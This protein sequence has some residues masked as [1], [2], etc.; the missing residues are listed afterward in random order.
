MSSPAFRRVA[1]LSL[2][3][4]LFV[5]I[6]GAYVRASGSGAGCG[7]HWPN[8]NGELIPRS[9]TAQTVIEF[10]HR[11]TSG[12]ALLLS[13]AVCVMAVRAFTK[14]HPTRRFAIAQLVLMLTEAALGALLVKAELV[15][16]NATAS[17]AAAMSIHLINTFLLVA[18][19]VLTVFHA[20]EGDVRA[21]WRGLAGG[22][23]WL[24]MSLVMLVGVSGAIAALGDTLVQQSVNNPFVDLLIRLRI[25]HPLIA[26]VAAAVM[27]F[28]GRF[29][30]GA[31]RGWTIALWSLVVLQLFA[32]LTNV[33]LQAPTW[34]QLV[35]LGLA[36]AVWVVL[37][38]ATR[39]WATA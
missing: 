22:L 3:W 28:L 4:S 27:V 8:C 16:N 21:K 19:M 26:V 25:L 15:A 24:A 20:W 17:R 11:T 14:G 18:A 36:D 12:V 39:K 35:H 23:S 6:W 32:G 1:V 9:P 34:M 2:V 30:F 37:L 10:T 38:V 29:T 31:T 13:I 7:D 33:A 5:I